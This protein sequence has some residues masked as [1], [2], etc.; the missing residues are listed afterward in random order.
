MQSVCEDVKQTKTHEAQVP[1]R[2]CL[3]GSARPKGA[4]LPF[5][6][7]YIHRVQSLVIAKCESQAWLPRIL[8]IRSCVRVIRPNRQMSR[9]G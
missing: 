5:S 8:V 1:E 6:Y 7:I 9:S 3:G 4:L 2:K